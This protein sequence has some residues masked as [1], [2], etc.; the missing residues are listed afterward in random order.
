MTTANHMCVYVNCGGNNKIDKDRS[1]FKFPVNDENRIKDWIKNCGNIKIAM[2]DVADLK[3]K[4]IC[5]KHFSSDNIMTSKKR[6]RLV[7]TA[8]PRNYA[9]TGN[10]NS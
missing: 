1:F 9:E 7:K 6:K 3:N 5:E 4:L 8:I 10:Y 2:M